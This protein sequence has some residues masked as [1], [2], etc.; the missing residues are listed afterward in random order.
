[1][2]LELQALF[3]AYNWIM[4]D[5]VYSPALWYGLASWSGPLSPPMSCPPRTAPHT[6]WW[7]AWTGAAGEPAAAWASWPNP[8]TLT[9]RGN[10]PPHWERNQDVFLFLPS[11]IFAAL[12]GF[13]FSACITFSW[14]IGLTEAC[15]A[16]PWCLCVTV[17]NVLRHGVIF[18][19]IFK[20]P[21]EIRAK[22]V[23]QA[24]TWTS[25][26]LSDSSVMWHIVRYRAA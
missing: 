20:F 13:I 9:W 21:F 1:M 2:N 22:S 5:W 7:L 17:V 12:E 23:D 6:A 8:E 10:P 3:P 16:S 4:T 24:W 19:H 26:T 14:Q 18:K 15:C 25:E 11:F